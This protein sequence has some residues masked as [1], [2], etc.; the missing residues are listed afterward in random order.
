M[1]KLAACLKLQEEVVLHSNLELVRF[2]Q[3]NPQ[4]F[5]DLEN[6]PLL[7]PPFPLGVW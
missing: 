4:K 2:L 1:G 6:N 3:K 7:F 5:Q